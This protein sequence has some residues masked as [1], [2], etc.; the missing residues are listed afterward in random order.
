MTT[1]TP[2]AA[3]RRA[4]PSPMPEAPPV[5]IAEVPLSSISPQRYSPRCA[6][7]NHE[8]LGCGGLRW[9]ALR[10]GGLVPPPKVAGVPAQMCSP[11][12]G[13]EDCA[14]RSA[15]SRTDQHVLLST[16]TCSLVRDRGRKYGL[17]GLER[18]G[19]QQTCTK[20]LLTPRLTSTTTATRSGS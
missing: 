11:H 2:R 4:A 12:C 3:S 14:Y 20:Q 15:R 9:G 16:R 8:V 17:R 6:P 7:P 5:T 13:D 18:I 10:C 19:W 1:F